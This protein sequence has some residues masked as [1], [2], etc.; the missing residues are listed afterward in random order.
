MKAPNNYLFYILLS[1][2]LSVL[3]LLLISIKTWLKYKKTT[4][5][6]INYES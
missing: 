4:K 2:G 1:Y 5:E 6:Q 3:I